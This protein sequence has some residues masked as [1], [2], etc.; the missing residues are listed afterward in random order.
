MIIDHN[1]TPAAPVAGVLSEAQFSVQLQ[2]LEATAEWPDSKSRER[3]IE[4]IKSKLKAHD[5]ALR[6][7][8]RQAQESD[9]QG[10]AGLMVERSD[11]EYWQRRFSEVEGWYQ[12]QEKRAVEAEAQLATAEGERAALLH[13]AK[14]LHSICTTPATGEI[15]RNMSDTPL[16][17]PAM[18]WVEAR[19]TVQSRNER[20]AL[21]SATDPLLATGLALLD[22]AAAGGEA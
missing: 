16:E 20:L 10:R 3:G 11:R 14:V 8:V 21:K 5:A 6:E 13:T 22:G 15:D 17:K 4:Q 12:S 7:Q 9:K 1:E 2:N 19:A 18:R